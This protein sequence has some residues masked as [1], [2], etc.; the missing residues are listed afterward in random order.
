MQGGTI[1]TWSIQGYDAGVSQVSLQGLAPLPSAWRGGVVA[2]I[3]FVASVAAQF[4]IVAHMGLVRHEVCAEHGEL[5]ERGSGAPAAP[6]VPHSLP[7]ADHD[8]CPL[9]AAPGQ[10]PTPS[11]T[12]VDVGGA[13]PLCFEALPSSVTPPTV[14]LTSLALLAVAPKTSPPA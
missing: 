7:T 9:A 5:V 3:A 12:V 8:H 14:S 10:A 11:L 13:P 2:A 1:A 6:A 4:G